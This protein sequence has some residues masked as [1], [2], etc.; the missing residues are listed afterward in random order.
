MT[1]IILPDSP[2]SVMQL[3]D[4]DKQALIAFAANIVNSVIDG[5]ENPLKVQVLVKKQEFVLEKIKE[6]I[7][8]SLKT[9]AAKYG[10]K[11]FDY[12]GTKCHYTPT[13]TS[14]DFEA[15]GDQELVRLQLEFEKVKA[16]LD[17]RKEWLKTMGGPEHLVDTFSGEMITV[18][19]PIKKSSMGIKVSLK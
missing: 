1:N 9:E 8:E 17:Q 10:E 2:S 16:K 18:Y 11:E 13:A 19:P 15:C 14:Y 7:K 3:F 12:A 4:A 5:N 6:G